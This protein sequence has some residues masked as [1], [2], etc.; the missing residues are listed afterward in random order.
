LVDEIS[1]LNSELWKILQSTAKRFHTKIICICDPAQ[2]PPVNEY[3][4][5]AFEAIEQQYFLT[6]VVRAASSKPM[7]ELVTV[8]GE[9][10]WSS[11]RY[12]SIQSNYTP[13]KLQAVW[14]LPKQS[15]L[16]EALRALHN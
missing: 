8:T 2:L 3:L 1:M 4:S 9:R 5:P 11:H 15:W 14:V 7:V 6:E 13:D 10:I 12:L 16:S